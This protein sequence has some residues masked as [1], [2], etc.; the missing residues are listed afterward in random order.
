MFYLSEKSNIS[1]VSIFALALPWSEALLQG[2]THTLTTKPEDKML[3]LTPPGKVAF[4][5]LMYN[6]CS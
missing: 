3:L 4:H 5:M 2:G 1:V 6:A